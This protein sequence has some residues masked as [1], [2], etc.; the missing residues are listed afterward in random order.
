MDWSTGFNAMRNVHHPIGSTN[1]D[2]IRLEIL[3]PALHVGSGF[4]SGGR[5]QRDGQMAAQ[6]SRFSW[7]QLDH[8]TGIEARASG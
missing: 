6:G 8:P 7:V 5:D 4:N 3:I 2:Q 1:V